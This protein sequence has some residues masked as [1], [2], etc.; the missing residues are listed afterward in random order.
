MLIFLFI[1]S[2]QV[3]PNV[4][5]TLP[6]TW[7]RADIRDTCSS[8]KRTEDGFVHEQWSAR[9]AEDTFHRCWNIITNTTVEPV[10]K[11]QS[12][13]RRPLFQIPQSTFFHCNSP[14]LRD[15]LS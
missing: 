3:G 12:C 1:A 14:A 9:N 4:L 10:L 2:V 5:P 13:V 7:A 6:I 15:H 11:N 8:L